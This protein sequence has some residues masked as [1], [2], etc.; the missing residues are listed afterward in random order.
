MCST[1][2][3]CYSLGMATTYTAHIVLENRHYAR[4]HV[5]ESAGAARMAAS[6]ALGAYAEVADAR[7]RLAEEGWRV[8]G[9]GVEAKPGRY[10]VE[11]EKLEER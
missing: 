1:V 3:S 7:L 4:V 9:E 8:L 5:V 11:V 6:Y 10:L 2:A